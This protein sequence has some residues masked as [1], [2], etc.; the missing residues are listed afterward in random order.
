MLSQD[1][2]KMSPALS[3]ACWE[4]KYKVSQLHCSFFSSGGTAAL[5]I[6]AGLTYLSLLKGQSQA[7]A[8]PP[9]QQDRNYLKEHSLRGVVNSLHLCLSS[10]QGFPSL[11]IIIMIFMTNY[12]HLAVILSCLVL[13][14]SCSIE[15]ASE[16]GSLVDWSWAFQISW[17]W[18]CSSSV[19]S[20][21]PNWLICFQPD[22]SISHIKLKWV[23]QR[24]PIL[25]NLLFP[26]Q[27]TAPLGI[28]ILSTAD[29]YT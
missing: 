13:C 9:A 22:E 21:G 23:K 28:S 19:S 10:Q 6:H 3:S 24:Q 25:K 15:P 26:C 8:H 14:C 1:H 2:Q 5:L 7:S 11:T 4:K 12:T 20:P 29:S 27:S 17:D 16:G 18:N